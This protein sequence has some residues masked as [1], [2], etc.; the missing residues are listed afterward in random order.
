M[1]TAAVGWYWIWYKH[2]FAFDECLA[3]S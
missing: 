3:A 2:I 1:M